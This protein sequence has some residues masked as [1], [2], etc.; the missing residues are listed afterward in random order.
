MK[1]RGSRRL[2]VIAGTAVLA[3]AL[4]GA[5]VASADPA[6]DGCGPEVELGSVL[7]KGCSDALLVDNGQYGTMA[8][9]YAQNRGIAE[10]QV[11]VRIERWNYT[12]SAWEFDSGGSKPIAAG[13]DTR[14]FSPSNIWSCG[15][16]ARERVRA[17]T[18]VGTGDW[19]EVVTPAPC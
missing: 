11:S 13:G 3:T 2:A 5:P 1:L 6:E 14:Y 12:T 10:V 8:L 7:Y 9:L 4:G 16:D 17:T 15:Q 18:A 19:S